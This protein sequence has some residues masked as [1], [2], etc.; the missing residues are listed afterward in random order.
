MRAAGRFGFTRLSP[1]AHGR[2]AQPL[3]YIRCGTGFK[4]NSISL[5]ERRERTA[6]GNNVSINSGVGKRRA[7]NGR[8]IESHTGTLF[9][10][11]TN[12]GKKGHAFHRWRLTFSCGRTYDAASWAAIGNRTQGISNQKQQSQKIMLHSCNNSFL[13]LWIQ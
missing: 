12:R 7:A 13:S 3:V 11:P 9:N 10:R 4:R 8:S 1:A 5:F 6:T 2:C